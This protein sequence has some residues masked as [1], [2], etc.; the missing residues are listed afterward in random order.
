MA[1]SRHGRSFLTP[2]EG[3]IVV[4]FPD[5]PEALTVGN[6]EADACAQAADCLDE[7]F[8]G[9][10]K[11]RDDIPEPSAKRAGQIDIAVPPLMAAKASLYLAMRDAKVSNVALAR[12]LDIDERQV[13][14]MLDPKRATR[15]PQIERALAVLGKGLEIRL[16]DRPGASCRCY[17]GCSSE[18]WM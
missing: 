15:L 1:C 16:I 17:E 12:K 11:R 13:R 5:L 3:Q 10:I 18:A 4:E 9:R 2:D 14:W 6:D 7:A 8:G